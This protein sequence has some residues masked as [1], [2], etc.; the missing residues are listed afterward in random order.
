MT[1]YTQ[2]M[3]LGHLYNDVRCDCR[4]LYIG[5]VNRGTFKGQHKV[6][7]DTVAI[8]VPLERLMLVEEYFKVY[9]EDKSKLPAEAAKTL[10]FVQGDYKG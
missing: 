4:G 7:V 5:V 8:H 1:P 6:E 3:V 2:V 9:N 10:Y